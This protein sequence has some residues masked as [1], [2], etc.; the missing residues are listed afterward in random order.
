MIYQDRIA[1]GSCGW[2]I[3]D[4]LVRVLLLLIRADRTGNWDLHL[5]AVSEMIPILH[6]AAHLAYAKSTRLYLDTMKKLPEIMTE[7]Q[8]MT[9]TEDGY[10][11]IRRRNEFWAGHFT[12]HT[13]AQALMRML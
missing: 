3:S 7:A 4:R 5:C 13:A 11:T 10:F 2:N 12:D 9:F 1:L 6:A 8:F